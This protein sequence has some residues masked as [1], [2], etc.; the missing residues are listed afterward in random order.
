MAA[1]NWMIQMPWFAWIALAAIIGG[2]VDSTIKSLIRHRERMA[3]IEHGM[4]PDG[5][6][7][8]D[9]SEATTGCTSARTRTRPSS[10]PGYA[11]E[12]VAKSN[13]PEL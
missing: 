11:S 10:V 9:D 8:D 5:L 6:L 12:P 13:L 4:H 7:D 2:I 1:T 3:M